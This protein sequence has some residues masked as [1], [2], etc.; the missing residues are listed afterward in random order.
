MRKET[1]QI[2]QVIGK[3]I[4]EGRQ[5][6][7][8]TQ[9]RFA[10]IV[11]LSV[12]SLSALENGAQFARMDTYC[13]IAEALKLPLS[14]LFAIQQIQEDSLEDQ[15]RLLFYDFETDEK[16]ALLDVMRAIKTLL[17]MRQL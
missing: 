4:R 17:H 8:L 14:S 11:G 15:F 13:K 3:N 16:K 1:F 10:E 12:Q 7:G 9:E 6:L 5:W 2:R